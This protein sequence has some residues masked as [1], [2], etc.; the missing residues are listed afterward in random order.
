VKVPPGRTVKEIIQVT[1]PVTCSELYAWPTATSHEK[2]L[3][4]TLEAFVTMHVAG[5]HRQGFVRLHEGWHK[6]TL[7]V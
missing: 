2:R 6:G 1:S 3:A 4:S 7:Y 5:N